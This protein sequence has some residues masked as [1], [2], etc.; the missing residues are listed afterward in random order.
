MA[1]GEILIIQY[2]LKLHLWLAKWRRTLW[3]NTSLN[4]NRRTCL[5]K[6]A[7]VLR[8]ARFSHDRCNVIN[9]PGSHNNLL[10]RLNEIRR[11]GF[12]QPDKCIIQLRWRSYIIYEKKWAVGVVGGHSNI[13]FNL[14]S[15]RSSNEEKPGVMI[16]PGHLLFVSDL[17]RFVSPAFHA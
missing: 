10:A 12:Q 17:F 13:S 7:G 8:S 4:L 2:V 14:Q 6:W 11:Q 3:L 15:F 9:T 1:D 16:S 5:L